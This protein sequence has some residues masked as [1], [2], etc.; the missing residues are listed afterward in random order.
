MYKAEFPTAAALVDNSVF[1]D[2][3]AAGAGND[4]CLTNLHYELIYLMNRI[5]LPMPKW[6]TYSK[7]LKEV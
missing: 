5:R 3:F 7:H 1:M 6:S 4:G 2:N